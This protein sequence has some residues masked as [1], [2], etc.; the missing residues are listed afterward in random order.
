MELNRILLHLAAKSLRYRFLKDTGRPGRPE[1][2]RLEVTQRCISKC[3]M[4]NIWQM[5]VSSPELEASDWIQLLQSPILSELKQLDV[6][7]G[8]PFLRDDLAEL[9]LGIGKLKATCLPQ[10]CS[11]AITT[12]SFY[13]CAVQKGVTEMQLQQIKD[14]AKQSGVMVGKMKKDEIIRA[15][16]QA[17]G[18]SACFNTGTATVCGQTNCLWREDCQ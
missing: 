11:V 14:I 3:L 4:C 7:G 16:Q 17:E 12:N 8:E 1:A 6:T 5:S 18:N 2:I 9:L 15:I 10:L 13:T